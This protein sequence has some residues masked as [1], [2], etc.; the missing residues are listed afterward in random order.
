MSDFMA[1]SDADFMAQGPSKLAEIESAAAEVQDETPAQVPAPEAVDETVDANA[2]TEEHQE[3]ETSGEGE[4]TETSATV[5]DATDANVE[6][7]AE[8]GEVVQPAAKPKPEGTVTDTS[9]TGLPEGAERIFA[10]F[11]ANGRDKIGRAHV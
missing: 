4:E 6:V 3:T 8:T 7:N 1:M 10:T 9:V 2:S 5:A 11:R